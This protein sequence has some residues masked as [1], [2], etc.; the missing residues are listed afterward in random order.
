MDWLWGALITLQWQPH[1]NHGVGP[2]ACPESSLKTVTDV[3]KKATLHA[4][5][6][7]LPHGAKHLSH[8][9]QTIFSQPM[10]LGR[11]GR[12]HGLYL[13]CDLNGTPCRALMDMGSTIFLVQFSSSSGDFLIPSMP[14]H[15]GIIFI[16][17]SSYNVLVCAIV[18]WVSYSRACK[19]GNRVDT[20]R[21]WNKQATCPWNFTCQR[22]EYEKSNGWY[23]GTKHGL[24]CVHMSAGC[25]WGS[26]VTVQHHTL[27]W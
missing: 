16:P 18:T 7:P 27:T 22:K 12:T 9:Q 21:V 4:T 20:E 17:L 26:A 25:T 15:L 3:G 23:G 14:Y 5:A 13:N 8:P 11:L 19:T 2:G 1:N 6:W 24:C 10:Q